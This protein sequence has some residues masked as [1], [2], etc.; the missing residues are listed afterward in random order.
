MPVK[1][2]RAHPGRG[3][4]LHLPFVTGKQLWQVAVLPAE[5]HNVQLVAQKERVNKQSN[6]MFSTKTKL[7]ATLN[8][9]H[10]GSRPRPNPGKN[11]IVKT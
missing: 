8:Q 4:A 7:R 9:Y 3:L 11:R 1:Q 10:S 5:R 6:H 2:L